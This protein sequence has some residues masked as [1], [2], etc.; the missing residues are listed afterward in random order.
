MNDWWCFYCEGRVGVVHLRGVIYRGCANVWLVRDADC[1][2]PRFVYRS[3]LDRR[4]R[5]HRRRRG[6]R[7]TPHS[8]RIHHVN[9]TKHF[10]FLSQSITLNP[11]PPDVLF[12]TCDPRPSR[13]VGHRPAR[14]V[15]TLI[16]SCFGAIRQHEMYQAVSN[17]VCRR[18]QSIH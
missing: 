4:H 12:S 10:A 5:R 9:I 6:E 1:V 13:G 3:S 15:S 18:R 7:E 2:A 11:R 8:A 14:S 17:I 16:L